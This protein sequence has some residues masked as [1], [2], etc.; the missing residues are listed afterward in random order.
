M[1]DLLN[2][3]HYCYKVCTLFIKNSGYNLFIDNPPIWTSSHFYKLILI[4]HSMIFQ[5]YQP[6]I[7]KGS[8]HYVTVTISNIYKKNKK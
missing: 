8:S 2:T 6:P 1:K 5:K 4:S 3:E 7:I